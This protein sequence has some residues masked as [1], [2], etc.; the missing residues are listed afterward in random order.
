[1]NALPLE[2]RPPQAPEHFLFRDDDL[3]IPIRRAV[4]AVM[5]LEQLFALFEKTKDDGPLSGNSWC[6]LG[7]ALLTVR[8]ELT[9][10]ANRLA[11]MPPSLFVPGP[12]IE[13]PTQLY[14][15]WRGRKTAEAATRTTPDTE[16]GAR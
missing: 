8:T 7:D 13:F 14:E 6:F 16:G 1:M 15:L 10:A 12:E 3:S 9:T 4:D 5:F 2:P 11:A